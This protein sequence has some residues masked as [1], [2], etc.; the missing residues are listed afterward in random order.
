[1]KYIIVI[2]VCI[3]YCCGEYSWP[4]ANTSSRNCNGTFGEYRFYSD[5]AKRH[6]HEGIDIRADSSDQKKYDVI[7]ITS[8][9]EITHNPDS[10]GY[11]YIVKTRY[12]QDDSVTAV[13]PAQGSRH[14]H[15]YE[16]ND[17]LGDSGVKSLLCT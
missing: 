8:C 12:Y 15:M 7:S 3:S 14:I 1:V 16:I 4:V 13:D 5:P 10:F 6:F 2:C 9:F 17:S 11:A